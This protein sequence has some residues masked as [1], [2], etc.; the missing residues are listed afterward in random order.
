MIV[1]EERE[2]TRVSFSFSFSFLFFFS[3]LS[4]FLLLLL[5]LRPL[6]LFSRSPRNVLL[7]VVIDK[8]TIIARLCS[9]HDDDETLSTMKILMVFKHFCAVSTSEL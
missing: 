2:R 9:R 5:L 4:F 7:E 3:L 8:R 1:N 6:L